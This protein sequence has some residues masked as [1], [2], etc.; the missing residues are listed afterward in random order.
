M[1]LVIGRV[2]DTEE[3]ELIDEIFNVRLPDLRERLYRSPAGFFF[4]C[5]HFAFIPL[6]LRHDEDDPGGY[7][8]QSWIEE[9][10]NDLR[11]EIV[12]CSSEQANEWLE[13]YGNEAA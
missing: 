2:Y 1:R 11:E 7:K 3:S 5:G 10:L 8:A 9:H 13:R 4:L 6:D 12:P